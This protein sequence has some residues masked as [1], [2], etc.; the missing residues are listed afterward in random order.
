MYVT[1]GIMT[2]TAESVITRPPC[3]L[4]QSS[5]FTGQ[6]GGVRSSA[7]L[8]A[9]HGMHIAAVTTERHND[10]CQ[11]VMFFVFLDEKTYTY[12]VWVFRVF[13]VSLNSVEIVHT[14]LTEFLWL[15]KWTT[16]AVMHELLGS[17]MHIMNLYYIIVGGKKIFVILQLM[18]NDYDK[19]TLKT[20]NCW[21]HV[22]LENCLNSLLL[23]SKKSLTWAPRTHSCN[24]LQYLLDCKTKYK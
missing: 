5:L 4:F 6:A 13:G 1:C 17:I 24:T 20:K 7:C 23:S 16:M 18:I 10:S 2:S 3:V 19:Y 11:N 15:K 9:P 8:H 21:L 14:V 22:I 12:S